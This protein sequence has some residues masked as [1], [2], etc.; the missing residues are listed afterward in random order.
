MS[1]MR[2]AGASAHIKVEHAGLSGM[3]GNAGAGRARKKFAGAGQ[4]EPMQRR[5]MPGQKSGAALGCR[6]RADCGFL[7][8]RQF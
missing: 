2:L 1:C 5:M 6:M 3:Y 4:S 7:G 8:R